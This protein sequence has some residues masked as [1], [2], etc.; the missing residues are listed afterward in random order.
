M[1]CTIL[2][3]VYQGF[4]LSIFIL[5]SDSEEKKILLFVLSNMHNEFKTFF[6]E[7]TCHFPL[8][9]SWLPVP[10]ITLALLLPLPLLLRWSLPKGYMQTEHKFVMLTPKPRHNLNISNL[11]QDK[12]VFFMGTGQMP[13]LSNISILMTFGPHQDINTCPHTDHHHHHAHHHHPM[14]IEE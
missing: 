5:Y 2:L 6:K 9:L 12:V 1:L 4:G 3:L 8:E 10:V 14:I 11:K 7:D 13:K